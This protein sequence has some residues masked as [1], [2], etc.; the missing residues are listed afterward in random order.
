MKKLVVVS[1]SPATEERKIH[2]FF[3]SRIQK[4]IMHSNWGVRKKLEKDFTRRMWGKNE[5]SLLTLWRLEVLTRFY[6]GN[7]HKI[8][9]KL[10]SGYSPASAERMVRLKTVR[11]LFPHSW[12]YF[13]KW[14][15]HTKF[16][17]N[18]RFMFSDRNPGLPWIGHWHAAK[19]RSL[20]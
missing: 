9:M 7:P 20:F 18:T 1:S 19:K 2:F 16:I 10:K 4:L 3:F 13:S 15:S 14:I 17:I 12:L 6:Y 5:K 8:M 11:S